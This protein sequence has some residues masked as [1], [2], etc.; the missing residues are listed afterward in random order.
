MVQTLRYVPVEALRELIEDWEQDRNPE[1]GY[2]YGV[3]RGLEFA[4]KA[5]REVIGE[6]LDGMCVATRKYL[7][8]RL[9]V[10]NAPS[11]P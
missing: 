2:D 4:A 10:D 5:L 11:Q 3:E 9:A 1:P 7:A 6:P 8:H